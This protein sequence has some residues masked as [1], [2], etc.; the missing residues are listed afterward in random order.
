MSDTSSAE[1]GVPVEGSGPAGAETPGVD[2]GA[3]AT[4]E[5]PRDYLDT[6]QYA[7]HHVRIKVDGED[8][9]V[10]LSEALQGY[11]RTQ[12][13]TRKT[14]TLA[15][16][17]REAQFALTLQQALENNPQQTLRILQEQYGTPEP[18][19]VSDDD[20]DSWLDDP[21]EARLKEYDARFAQ[22][23]QQRADQEL[24]VALRVLQDR[25]GEDF[26]PQAVVGKAAQQQRMDLEAIHKELMFDK[27]WARQQAERDAQAKSQADEQARTTAKAG[28]TMHGGS[29]V[30]GAIAEPESGRSPTIAEAF[31]AAQREHGG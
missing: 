19:A 14:Q 6:D 13:Y 21:V 15:E 23:E 4:P 17:Q 8:V 27:L 20:D 25:Y 24:R 5:A 30:N 29:S 7:G 11:S 16:Q 28:L 3:D 22:I 10:P 1:A 2:V 12:D 18:A 31:R 26:D 9:D